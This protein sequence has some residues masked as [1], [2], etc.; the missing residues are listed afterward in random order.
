MPR[1]NKS[2]SPNR[3]D[4][5][6]ARPLPNTTATGQPYGAAGEQRAAQ[7]QIPMA[8]TPISTGPAPAANPSAVPQPAPSPN[9]VLAQ[10]QAHNGPGDIPPLDRPTERPNEPVTHGLPMGPGAGPEALTG[11]GAVAREGVMGQATLGQLLSTLASQPN[12]PSAVQDL[13]VRAQGG[14]Q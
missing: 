13:A 9:D 1:A 14:T 10:A 11:I 5:I 8:P 6:G 7:G 4:L 2:V 12:A 3:S